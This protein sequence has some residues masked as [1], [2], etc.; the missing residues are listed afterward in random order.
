MWKH[1][2]MNRLRKNTSWVRFAKRG[3]K[4]GINAGK[5]R[6]E[7]DFMRERTQFAGQFGG[8]WGYLVLKLVEGLPLP[9]H[10]RCI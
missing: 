8:E 9:L 1:F 3:K 6:R 5:H 10:Y 7:G 2:G 4:R